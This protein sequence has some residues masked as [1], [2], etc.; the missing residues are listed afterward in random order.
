MSQEILPFENR[1]G[2]TPNS[3]HKIMAQIQTESEHS[4][5][6]V[7]G[8]SSQMHDSPLKK[9]IQLEM[10]PVTQP[11]IVENSSHEQSIMRPVHTA[12]PNYDQQL[13]GP[14]NAIQ[15]IE[16]I[17]I[18][19]RLEPTM[20][21]PNT[22]SLD[23]KTPFKTKVSLLNRESSMGLKAELQKLKKAAKNDSQH[24]NCSRDIVMFGKVL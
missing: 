1:A 21:T 11:K 7:G 24:K 23:R 22:G 8:R 13:E 2:H 19:Q 18:K 12:E 4:P 9:C 14:P 6:T 15:F 3:L 5:Y 17:D 20:S 10:V 16:Q